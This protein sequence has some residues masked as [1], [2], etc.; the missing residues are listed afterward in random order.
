MAARALLFL[1]FVVLALAALQVWEL[2][3]VTAAR[4]F[5]PY[6]LEWMEGGTL[7]T[8]LRAH[9]GLPFYAPPTPDYIPFIYPPLY[10]RL[11]GA[12]GHLFPIGYALGRSV[13][14]VG[15]LVGAAA[16]AWV[17]RRHGAS[18]PLALGSAVLFLGTYEEVGTFFDL[19]RIDGLSIALLG[20][21]LALGSQPG[22]RMA[23]AA[24]LLLALAFACKHHAAIFGFPLVFWR[25]RTQGLREALWFAGAAVIPALGFTA[26]LQLAT[27]GLFLTWLLEVPAAHGMVAERMVPKLELITTPTWKLRATG[28][29]AEC[30]VA[31]PITTVA[32]LLLPRWMRG[33][34]WIAVSLVALLTVTLMRGHTGGY[35]NV[36][37]PMMWVLAAWPALLAQ[38]FE[39]RAWA[40]PLATLL[41]GAQLWEGRGELGRYAP[42]AEDRVAAEAFVEELRGLP[43]PLLIPHAPY[44]AVLAGKEPH[45]ALIALWD[46][47][48]AG[49]PF[50]GGVKAVERS[51]EEGRW[52]AI[53]VPD[54]GLGYGLKEHYRKARV[55]RSPSPKTRTGWPVRLR[56]VWTPKEPVPTE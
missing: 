19:V 56:H 15:T 40:R 42:T 17:A 34:Y 36:L 35:L 47:N 16:L 44:A 23:L 53:V 21:A 49:S 31:L 30:L 45:F 20:W 22:R 18:W 54:D 5:Y 9:Q 8:G 12:L 48:H 41:V 4:L 51:L 2:A 28:A 6:D 37:I 26:A 7:L 27:G 32:A 25:W 39:G 55:L 29:A 46:I 3:Q 13:S 10:A 50:R 43:E 14:V 1:E 24:G 11:L 38:P 33:G 52:A